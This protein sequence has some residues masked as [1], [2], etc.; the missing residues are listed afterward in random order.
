M[1]KKRGFYGILVLVFGTPLLLLILALPAPTDQSFRVYWPLLL[2]LAGLYSFFLLQQKSLKEETGSLS[3]LKTEEPLVLDSK[4]K[5]RLVLLALGLTM[6][7]G[8]FWILGLVGPVALTLLALLGLTL[9]L[10]LGIPLATLL[11]PLLVVVSPL[12]ALLFLINLVS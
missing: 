10:T 3:S 12:L 11:V 1:K 9:F 5:N 2:I 7:F 8:A 6:V 4:G